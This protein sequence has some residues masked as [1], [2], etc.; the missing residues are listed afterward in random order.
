MKKKSNDDYLNVSFFLFAILTVLME[1]QRMNQLDLGK[2]LVLGQQ[3]G[4]L[5]KW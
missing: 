1:V 4:F 3:E 5:T 2:S